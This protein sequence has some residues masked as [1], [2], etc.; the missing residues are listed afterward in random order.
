MG[1]GVI[2]NWIVNLWTVALLN[3]FSMVKLKNQKILYLVLWLA[4]LVRNHITT[5]K[6]KKVGSIAALEM[7][8][9]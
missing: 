6:V 7:G 3:P 1:S 2:P 5:C 9:G 4:T 8:A